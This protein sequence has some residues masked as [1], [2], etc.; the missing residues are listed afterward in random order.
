M[1]IT[2]S[3]ESLIPARFTANMVGTTS[4]TK[5]MIIN[6]QNFYLWIELCMHIFVITLVCLSYHIHV[7][8]PVI[9]VDDMWL[10][11][12]CRWGLGQPS[13][14]ILWRGKSRPRDHWTS[15]SLLTWTMQSGSRINY[16]SVSRRV[17]SATFLWLDMVRALPSSQ[18]HPS[19]HNSIWDQILGNPCREKSDEV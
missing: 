6:I 4:K 18:T 16:S 5:Q 11:S 8:A 13:V 7:L 19:P 9:C 15:R 12:L 3:N 2:L 17:R 10:D 1:V 14:W